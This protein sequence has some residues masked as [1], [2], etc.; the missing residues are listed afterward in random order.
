MKSKKGATFLSMD[1]FPD[2]IFF[3]N[4]MSHQ[5]IMRFLKMK[6]LDCW[7]DAISPE[8]TTDE[9]PLIGKTTVFTCRQ[10]EDDVLIPVWCV[11]KKYKEA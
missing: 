6:K 1:I 3:S 7:H 11:E 4:G 5:E 8:T 9:L 10:L 2:K